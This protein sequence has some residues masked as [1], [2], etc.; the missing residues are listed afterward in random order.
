MNSIFV[1]NNAHTVKRVYDP[2]TTDAL[3]REAG[4]D[5]VMLT[6]EDVLEGK[7]LEADYIF[8]TWGM[9]RF[10]VEEITAYLPK[11]K[12]VFYGAGSV[13]H[14]AGAF[15]D[16][17]VK[18]F[19]AWG[20]N[21]VPVAEYT[22]A[23][24]I[25][26]NK[27][28]YGASRMTSG[29]AENRKSAQIYFSSFPGNYG[30]S[31]GLIGAGMIGSLVARMLKDYNLKV[32]VFD[33]FLPAARAEELGVELCTLE[34]L[35]STCQ[36]ISNHLANN[37]Q[38]RGMLH[39]ELF[40]LMKPNATFINTGRGAQVVEADLI[41][42]LTECPNRTAVL[43]V[44]DPEPPVEGHDFYNLPNV[45]LTPHIAGSAGD[46]VRRMGLYMLEEFRLH[47]VGEKT[48][49]EVSKAMLATMA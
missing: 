9:P 12:A 46:E 23:Q 5:P 48:R 29:A 11:L 3:V 13:R 10:T 28:Y 19:S 26:A 8:S 31:V 44:T 45:V 36:T 43:D 39:Y 17:G 35:F 34:E 30:C 27:G 38:T 33:P 37:E 42:A 7:A 24:I 6:R 32:K 2:D 18:V 40:R 20:A 41:R 21:A 49:Y 1:C 4:L 22:V 15:L 14:F 16:A 25:L 47:V